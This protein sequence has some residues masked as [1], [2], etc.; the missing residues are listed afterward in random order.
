MCHPHFKLKHS[1]LCPIKDC[2]LEIRM[3]TFD[4]FEC[5]SP[6][7]SPVD[8]DA[9]DDKEQSSPSGKQKRM[10]AGQVRAAASPQQKRAGKVIKGHTKQAKKERAKTSKR[11]F[12]ADCPETCKN[13]SSYCVHHFNIDGCHISQAKKAGTLEAYKQ[14]TACPH[15]CRTAFDAWDAENPAGSTKKHLVEWGQWRKRYGVT[16]GVTQRQGEELLSMVDFVAMKRLKGYEKEDAEAEWQQ[17]IDAGNEGEGDGRSR[18]LWIMENKKRFRDR[19]TYEDN[20]WDEGG[21]MK[22]GSN[23]DDREK[24]QQWSLDSSSFG[25]KFMV[26]AKEAAS[27]SSTDVDAAP[28]VV[29]TEADEINLAL[30]C[31]AL[32]KSLTK[33]LKLARKVF[34]DSLSACE[35]AME[36]FTQLPSTA[37]VT[38]DMIA[39]NDLVICR[40]FLGT[41][42]NAEEP[43]QVSIPDGLRKTTLVLPRT[44]GSVSGAS[45]SGA[46]AVAAASTP[47]KVWNS[48]ESEE[49]VFVFVFLC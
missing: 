22:K 5:E 32:H 27:A 11:C 29:Q 25:S 40:N 37:V 39:Y 2:L 10:T 1:A 26:R 30:A 41:Y 48:S 4:G 49:S 34:N 19:T 8:S 20:G 21:K 42:I 31:P 14:V 17:M 38:D 12:V 33:D 45:G 47:T 9:E 16:V 3:A 6:I 15:K 35:V 24:M 28:A 46:R 43:I 13:K 18:K 36:S 44:P 23:P 7:V